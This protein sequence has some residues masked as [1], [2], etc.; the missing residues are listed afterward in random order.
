[1]VYGAALFA[2][3]LIMWRLS[4]DLV[5][6]FALLGGGVVAALI[7]GGLLLLL[8]QQPAAPSGSCLPALEIRL[9]VNCCATHW[10]R[11]ASRWHLA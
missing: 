6:T 3:G 4:L 11:P 1:M 9:W 5:L 8:L 7:L 2:L 10:Q